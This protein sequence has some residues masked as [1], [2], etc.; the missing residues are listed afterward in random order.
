MGASRVNKNNYWKVVNFRVWG[1]VL[2]ERASGDK[3]KCMVS[4]YSIVVDGSSKGSGVVM[5][6]PKATRIEKVCICVWG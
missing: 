6:H 1:D 3:W 5:D 2:P 4:G